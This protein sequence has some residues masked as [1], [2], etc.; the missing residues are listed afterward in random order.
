MRQLLSRPGNKPGPLFE[1]N[2]GI[3]P[4]KGARLVADFAFD[5]NKAGHYEGTRG[6]SGIRETPFYQ[7][8][9]QTNAVTRGH[10]GSGRGSI[11]I[12]QHGGHRGCDI[13]GRETNFPSEG[14]KRPLA[15]E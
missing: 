10:R 8:L 11:R 5:A 2:A 9:V 7:Q 1:S 4:D 12:N 6:T 15:H 3:C 13:L 14:V